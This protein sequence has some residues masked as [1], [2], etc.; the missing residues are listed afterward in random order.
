MHKLSGCYKKK[1]LTKMIK[2]GCMLNTMVK[3][4][5]QIKCPSHEQ[6]LEKQRSKLPQAFTDQNMSK[7]VIPL[8]Y[9]HTNFV[10]FAFQFYFSFYISVF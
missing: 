8:P 4:K 9:V 2:S 5:E 1:I 10:P 7:A 3:F 6:N